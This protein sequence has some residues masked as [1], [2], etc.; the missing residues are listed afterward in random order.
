MGCLVLTIEVPFN[1]DNSSQTVHPIAML[2]KENFN[3]SLT[4]WSTYK[5]SNN[6]VR[7]TTF[8]GSGSYQIVVIDSSVCSALVHDILLI[9]S[10]DECVAS[11]QRWLKPGGQ[12]LIT[13]Y[14][15]SPG[16][17]SEQFKKYLEQRQYH[18]IDVESYGKVS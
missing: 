4:N 11:Q 7:K 8:S 2:L 3:C 9:K 17:H 10:T 1:C 14:C 12:L 6:D 5:L 13:D 15:C 16:E 18:L